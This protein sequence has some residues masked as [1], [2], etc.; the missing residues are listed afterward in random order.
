MLAAGTM[1]EREVPPF[2][3]TAGDRARLRAVNRVGLERRGITADAKKQIKAL[4]KMLKTPG[5]PLPEIVER[6]R[7][8]TPAAARTPE[9]LRMIRFLET[10]T[11]GLTR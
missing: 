11:R 6:W 8:D 5:L 9:A 2:C 4:F 7:T 3:I 10:A 1:V